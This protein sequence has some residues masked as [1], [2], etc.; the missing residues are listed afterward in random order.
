MS[1]ST[2]LVCRPWSL[3]IWTSYSLSKRSGRP[4]QVYHPTRH[5]GLR[6]SRGFFYKR[7]WPI[8]KDDV[9]RAFNALWSRDFRSLNLLNEAFL[10]LLRK[11]VNPEEIRDCRPISLIHSFAKLVSK[12]LANRLARFLSDLVRPNQSAF[13]RGR[14][15]HDNFQTVQLTCRLLHSVKRPSMLLKIDMAK[16]FDRLLASWAFLL[17]LLEF[18]GFS[19]RWRDWMSALLSTASTKILLNK[20]Q[21]GKQDLPCSRP[22]KAC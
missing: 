16:A 4:L 14:S 11:K 20:W 15:I 19:R 10:I 17:E 2:L 13:I 7:A 22:Q 9:M 12:C 5:Q 3:H 18:M 21:T 1:G 6:D 8:I